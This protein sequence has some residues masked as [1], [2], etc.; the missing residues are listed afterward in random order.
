MTVVVEY[1]G[2]KKQEEVKDVINFWQDTNHFW[3]KLKNDCARTF[4][5]RNVRLIRIYDKEKIMFEKDAEEYVDLSGNRNYTERAFKDGVEFGY[6]KANEWHK[7]AD[8]GLPI[9][10]NDGTTYLLYTIYGEGGSPVVAHFAYR[11]KQQLMNVWTGAILTEDKIIAWKES[12]L[13]K[14]I[15]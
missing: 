6:N 12:V 10:K 7:V 3:L 5:R 15:E 4:F 2:S 14:E 8:E 11:D 13:P 1:K 9:N